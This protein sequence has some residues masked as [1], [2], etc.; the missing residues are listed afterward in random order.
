[1]PAANAETYP[2][3]LMAMS[4]SLINLGAALIAVLC[5]GH[6]PVYGTL[7]AY[8]AELFP[9]SVRYSGISIGYQAASIVLGGIT[10]ML[11]SALILWAG[12][13]PWAVVLMMV[14]SALIAAGT[15]L[16]SPETY[17]RDLKAI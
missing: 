4:G 16:I 5:L 10:P 9:T 6:G 17:R 2:F 11:A 8:Y 12:G 1:V 15:M 3:F 7:A 14:V 13:S